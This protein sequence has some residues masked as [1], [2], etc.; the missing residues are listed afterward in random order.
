MSTDGIVDESRF[1]LPVRAQTSDLN[2]SFIGN[3]CLLMRFWE[4]SGISRDNPKTRKSKS[5]QILEGFSF[6]NWAAANEE[7]ILWW[8]KR[9]PA[10]P[11]SEYDLSTADCQCPVSP[12]NRFPIPPTSMTHHSTAISATTFREASQTA[13]EVG[14]ELWRK[15]WVWSSGSWSPNFR[16]HCS[17]DG[18]FWKM[19]LRHAVGIFLII[20][21]CWF[22]VLSTALVHQRVFSFIIL[23][24]SKKLS[25]PSELL[26]HQKVKAKTINQGFSELIVVAV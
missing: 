15:S 22:L 3:T 20:R 9:L 24:R 23:P 26:R 10:H 2:L 6:D 4:L 8:I 21:I 16:P 5:S 17:D 14:R 7:S 12:T 25:A 19:P 18:P 1:H 13:L 11:M